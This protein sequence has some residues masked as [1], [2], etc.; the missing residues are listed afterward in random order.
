[1]A[2]DAK[3]L[4]AAFRKAPMSVA[5]TLR[6]NLNV[7]MLDVERQA[8]R[9]HRFHSKSVM[10]VRS[11]QHEVTSDGLEGRAYIN[12]GVAKYTKYQH[13]GTGLYGAMHRAYRVYPKNKGALSF[14]MGGKHYLVPRQPRVEGGAKNPYFKKLEKEGIANIIWKGYVTI[15]GIRPDHFLYRAFAAQKPYVLARMRGAVSAALNMAGLK[16]VR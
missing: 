1:M 8:R 3:A 14:V 11:I 4:L 7:A 12:D 2:V 10:A 5:K 16:G 6:T 13:E 15:K 9:N